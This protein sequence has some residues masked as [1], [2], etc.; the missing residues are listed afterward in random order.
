[1][2]KVTVPRLALQS[3]LGVIKDHILP[4]GYDVAL[5]CDRPGHPDSWIF[6]GDIELERAMRIITYAN[7][8]TP[9]TPN[10]KGDDDARQR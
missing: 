1:M 7:L 5:L 2:S 9:A 4:G 6:L 10:T 8:P 3:M